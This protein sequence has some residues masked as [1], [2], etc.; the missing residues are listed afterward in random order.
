MQLTWQPGCIMHR[1]ITIT[2]NDLWKLLFKDLPVTAV[3]A[4]NFQK[5][6][7]GAFRHFTH[8]VLQSNMQGLS[9][10]LMNSCWGQT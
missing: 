2:L 7:H 8:V 9:V 5:L 6:P 3:G 4:A 1:L 10:I